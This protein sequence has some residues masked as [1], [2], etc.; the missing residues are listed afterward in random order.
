MRLAIMICIAVLKIPVAFEYSLMLCG[1]LDFL[2]HDGDH[3]TGPI[4]R[5]KRFYDMDGGVVPG[6]IHA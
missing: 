3:S 2:F 4:F 1:G 6:Y 5:I